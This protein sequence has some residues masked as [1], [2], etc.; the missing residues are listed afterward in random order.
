MAEQICTNEDKVE[1]MS[2]GG[3]RGKSPFCQPSS[4]VPLCSTQQHVS[5]NIEQKSFG[6]S[7]LIITDNLT[8]NQI[9]QILESFYFNA[10]KCFEQYEAF[11]SQIRAISE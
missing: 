7:P 8:A 6:L 5:E 10:K 1:K 4:A 11:L 3:D 2:Q 9:C